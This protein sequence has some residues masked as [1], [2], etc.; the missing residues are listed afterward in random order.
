MNADQAFKQFIA[1]LIDCE[2]ADHMGD[3]EPCQKAVK[4]FFVAMPQPHALCEKGRKILEVRLA[5]GRP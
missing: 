4:S 3:C 2:F 1:H 5:K